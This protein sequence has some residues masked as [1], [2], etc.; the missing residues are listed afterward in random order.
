MNVL[1]D[2]VTHRSDRYGWAGWVHWEA[3]GAHFYAWEQPD[4]SSAST[5]T[6]RSVQRR[7]GRVH[8]HLLRRDRARRVRVLTWRPPVDIVCRARRF[9]R[10]AHRS[11]NRRSRSASTSAGP[12]TRRRARPV[13]RAGRVPRGLRQHARAARRRVRPV[14]AG[15][16]FITVVDHAAGAGRHDARARA[17]RR[18][19]QVARR[20]A[21]VG[22][23]RCR[24]LARSGL[25]RWDLDR[26]WDLA[27]VG[28]AP[29]YRGEAA[30]GLVTQALLQTLTMLG[31]GWGVDRYVAILDV[32]VLR[33]LQWR[34][35][36][37]FDA[38]PGVPRVRTSA[39]PRACRC[40]A[41]RRGPRTSRR[42]FRSCTSCSSR[43][44]G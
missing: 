11:A 21:R 17:V 22:C 19:V 43:A 29:E 32:P 41:G 34:I 16:V 7:R 38:F 37:P 5:S 30:L 36:R 2:P 14:R 44:A 31:E 3:S 23:G 8:A 10:R 20:R 40:G 42:R 35:G 6:L 12:T 24:V 25:R 13:R 9:R 18:R 33:M 15:S 26:V 39:R 4:C 1:L 27:T 28:G